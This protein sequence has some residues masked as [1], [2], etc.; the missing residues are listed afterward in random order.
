MSRSADEAALPAA[1]CWLDGG[2]ATKEGLDSQSD[3]TAGAVTSAT[4]LQKLHPYG[5]VKHTIVH[6]AAATSAMNRFG[7]RRNIAAQVTTC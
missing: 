6:P 2:G 5:F 7:E 4:G 3:Q 1:D